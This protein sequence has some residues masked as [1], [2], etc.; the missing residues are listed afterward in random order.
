MTFVDFATFEKEGKA[1][2]SSDPEGSRFQFLRKGT[3]VT[4][5]VTDNTK[6]LQY[7]VGS[8]STVNVKK[9]EKL[10]R[11]FVS[12]TV[13]QSSNDGAALSDSGEK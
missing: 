1:V 3:A 7:A 11:W 8:E 2:V 6:V 12:A 5:K 9:I 4:L 13:K 10:I